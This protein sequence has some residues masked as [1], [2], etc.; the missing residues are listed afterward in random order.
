MFYHIS[1]D[2]EIVLHPRY[3][4]AQLM[5]TVKQKLFTEV[6][7]TCTGIVQEGFYLI[8]YTT[9]TLEKLLQHSDSKGPQILRKKIINNIKASGTRGPEGGCPPDIRR[10]SVTSRMGSVNFAKHIIRENIEIITVV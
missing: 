9:Q 7:G 1:L 8:D 3:F 5:D 10:I 6:E 2:H 4:G